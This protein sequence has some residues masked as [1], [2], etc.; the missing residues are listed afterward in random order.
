MVAHYRAGVR[1]TGRGVVFLEFADAD[2]FLKFSAWKP[3]DMPWRPWMVWYVSTT[4]LSASGRP[5]TM[6]RWHE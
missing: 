3:A 2:D 6:L 1:G 5:W 4:T